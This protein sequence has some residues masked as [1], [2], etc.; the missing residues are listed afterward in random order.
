MQDL[1]YACMAVCAA[2]GAVVLAAIAAGIICRTSCSVP[3][4]RWS[5]V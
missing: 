3:L 1:A 2:L 5:P 4:F